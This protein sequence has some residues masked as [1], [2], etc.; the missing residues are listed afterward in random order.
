MR[1]NCQI[2]WIESS[3]RQPGKSPCFVDHVCVIHIM[4]V[5]ACCI[6]YHHH[7]LDSTPSSP[8]PLSKLFRARAIRLRLRRLLSH[9]FFK[10]NKN[11]RRL[12]FRQFSSL[13]QHPSSLSHSLQNCA[14]CYIGHLELLRGISLARA[15][16][17]PVD[18]VIQYHPFLVNPNLPEDKPI[19]K[20]QYFLRKFGSL[21]KSRE[22]L[23]LVRLRAKEEGLNL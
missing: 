23:E 22:I 15:R 10:D 11:R 21:E 19:P 16:N 3:R 13:S 12:R 5:T 9:G 17:L 4:L 2:E 8:S 20:D 18:F 14:W 6:I 7:H 1:W